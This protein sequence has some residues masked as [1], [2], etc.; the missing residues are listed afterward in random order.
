LRTEINK[1]QEAT[2]KIAM[3]EINQTQDRAD[4]VRSYISHSKEFDNLK[5]SLKFS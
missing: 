1:S 2:G 3:I 5:V 4:Q